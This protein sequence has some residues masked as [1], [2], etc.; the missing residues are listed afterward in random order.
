MVKLRGLEPLTPACKAQTSKESIVQYY[1]QLTWEQ[2]A[3]PISVGP[4]TFAFLILLTFPFVL[5][6]L[7]N[8]FQAIDQS[9]FSYEE[10]T[11]FSDKS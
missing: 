1:R 7:A 11:H 4:S 9:V 2:F 10:R 6:G 8:T 5:E 3:P